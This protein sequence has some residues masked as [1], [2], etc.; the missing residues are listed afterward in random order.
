MQRAPCSRSDASGYGKYTSCQSLMRS[1][2]GLVGCFFLWISMKPVALPIGYPKQLGKAR[3]ALLRASAR[4]GRERALVLARHHLEHPGL[5]RR[6]VGEQAFGIRAAGDLDV[7][8]NE[9]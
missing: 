7:P 6:P 9:L 3:L 8:L 5:D 4:L 1:A 2:T